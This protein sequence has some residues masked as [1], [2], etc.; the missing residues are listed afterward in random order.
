[1]RAIA[2]H[3]STAAVVAYKELYGNLY[4]PFNFVVPENDLNYPQEAWGVKLGWGLNTMK[5]QGN[6]AHS[7]T[8]R[9]YTINAPPSQ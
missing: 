6:T 8:Q 7:A 9:T 3:R 1:M 4:V 5:Y 2:V